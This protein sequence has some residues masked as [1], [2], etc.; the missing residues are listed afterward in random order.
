MDSSGQLS[1]PAVCSDLL[2]SL[3]S[4]PILDTVNEMDVVLHKVSQCA[5]LPRLSESY[6]K[7]IIIVFSSLL[8]YTVHT[9]ARDNTLTL[10]C[11]VVCF[12]TSTTCVLKYR[13]RDPVHLQLILKETG[14]EGGSGLILL[15]GS[16]VLS[17]PAVV[18]TLLHGGKHEIN[19]NRNEKTLTLKS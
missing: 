1:S 15:G 10:H 14:T 9:P 13:D 12:S 8:T 5:A 6:K 11:F 18:F 4:P 17:L 3:C 7:I 2:Q 19:K 16:G